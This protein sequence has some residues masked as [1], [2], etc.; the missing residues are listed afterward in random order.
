MIDIVV[1][2]FL[3]V[4]FIKIKYL[5]LWCFYSFFLYNLIVILF[6]KR[7]WYYNILVI[8]V[9]LLVI[10]VYLYRIIL[11]V[12]NCVVNLS[13]YIIYGFIYLF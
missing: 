8:L 7:S 6:L 11:F 4:L 3:D 9:L 5:I 2:L 1:K 13:I 10:G 12:W